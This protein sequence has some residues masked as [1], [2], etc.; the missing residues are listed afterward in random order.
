MPTYAE[1][2]FV[3]VAPELHAILKEAAEVAGES[4]TAYLD[5]LLR[6]AL[7]PKPDPWEVRYAGLTA[8]LQALRE[9]IRTGAISAEPASEPAAKPAE[10]PPPVKPA[11]SLKDYIRKMRG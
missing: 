10:I 8:E 11:E 2:P 7:I 5:K 3:R 6:A 4:M 1:Q 9:Q